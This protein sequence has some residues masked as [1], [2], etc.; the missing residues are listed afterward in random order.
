MKQTLAGLD[1]DSICLGEVLWDEELIS[2]PT[3]A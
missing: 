2:T 3:L 1:L